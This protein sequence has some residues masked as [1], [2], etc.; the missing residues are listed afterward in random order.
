[1]LSAFIASDSRLGFWEFLYHRKT[2]FKKLFVWN[3]QN[4]QK[5][6]AFSQLSGLYTRHC[7]KSR[8]IQ[9]RCTGSLIRHLL[10]QLIPPATWMRTKNKFE[11]NCSLRWLG[12]TVS[13]DKWIS[14]QNVRWNALAQIKQKVQ[15]INFN[16]FVDFLCL[17]C[18][19]RMKFL[20]HRCQAS[21]S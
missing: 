8:D 15:F 13:R 19:P 9:N 1:M 21:L 12:L 2:V 11:I 3:H 4:W 7:N 17:K 6:P 14:W 10:F 16:K 5:D 18:H 20:W